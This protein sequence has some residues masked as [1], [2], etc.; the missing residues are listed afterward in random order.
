[1]PSPSQALLRAVMSTKISFTSGSFGFT[2]GISPGARQTKKV[3]KTLCTKFQTEPK[4]DLQHASTIKFLGWSSSSHWLE[5]SLNF[6]NE[7]NVIYFLKTSRVKAQEMEL[8]TQALAANASVPPVFAKQQADLLRSACTRNTVTWVKYV[9][10][11]CASGVVEKK[12]AY[13]LTVVS[14]TVL[15]PCAKQLLADA[16]WKTTKRRVKRVLGGCRLTPLSAYTKPYI[17][18]RFM[19]WYYK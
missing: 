5:I 17:I 6:K 11:S 14:S 12:V 18:L 13:T 7:P 15:L 10:S 1:M 19:L 9:V 2:N 4:T 3:G 16:S 8:K